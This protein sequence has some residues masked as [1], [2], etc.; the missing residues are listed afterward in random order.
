LPRSVRY[1]VN[2]NFPGRIGSTVSIRPGL[3]VPAG[4]NSGV[5][6]MQISINAKRNQTILVRLLCGAYTKIK[7]TF[8][9]DVVVIAIDGRSLGVPPFGRYNE[10]YT[11]PA[12][13]PIERSTAQRMDVLIR[14][15]RSLSSYGQIEYRHHLRDA[16]L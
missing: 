2:I 4:L 6:G 1:K 12:G 7:I 8:P 3:T 15:S 14:S 11:I 16:F 13:K 5:A 10:P 9:V